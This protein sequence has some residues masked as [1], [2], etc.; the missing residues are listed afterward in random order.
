MLN[1]EFQA[2]KPGEKW[3]SDIT[4]VW[5]VEGWLYLVSVIDLYS[6]KIV[7][8]QM[9]ERID[10]RTR[11]G[12]SSAGLWPSASRSW[13]TA[14]L[15]RGSQYASHDYQKQLVLYEMIGSMSRK[16][17]CYDNACIESFHSVLKKELIYLNRYETREQAKQS[18][19]EYIEFF[20]NTRRIHSSIDYHT[21][22]EYE[23]L[24]LNRT[25]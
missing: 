6:R 14:H 16:G 12:G 24:Y 1:R 5:T 2:T 10:Q 20:Y 19:F 4:Y 7:G 21:P 8:W 23:R 3:V 11:D 18:I 9:G 13:S 17:N 25:A 15:D 22:S